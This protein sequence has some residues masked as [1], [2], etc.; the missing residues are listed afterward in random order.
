MLKLDKRR[1]LHH[2]HLYGDEQDWMKVNKAEVIKFDLTNKGVL[3]LYPLVSYLKCSME[4]MKTLS[5]VDV[6]TSKPS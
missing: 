4:T 5:R 2:S 3:F 6:W 1:S